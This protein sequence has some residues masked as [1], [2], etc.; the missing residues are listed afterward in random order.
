MSRTT[1]T[2]IGLPAPEEFAA[3]VG[4]WISELG[5]FLGLK[6]KISHKPNVTIFQF[7]ICLPNFRH[8]GPIMNKKS[9]SRYPLPLRGC[10]GQ[11]GIL[12]KETEIN[13]ENWTRERKLNLGPI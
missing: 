6:P 3:P 1:T 5:L 8:L 9:T 10:M 7:Y 2:Y 4:L 13:K 12:N 11:Q